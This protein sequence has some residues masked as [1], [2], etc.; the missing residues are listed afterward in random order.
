MEEEEFRDWPRRGAGEFS[1]VC[2]ENTLYLHRGSGHTLA[3][4]FK[5]H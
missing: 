2:D 4:I 1:C 3:S 5:M